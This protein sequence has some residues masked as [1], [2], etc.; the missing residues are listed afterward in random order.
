MSVSKKPG[1]TIVLYHYCG[2]SR[3]FWNRRYLLVKIFQ[4]TKNIVPCSVLR[5]IRTKAYLIIRINNPGLFWT[6]KLVQNN[7][8][9]T[10]R[11]KTEQSVVILWV[12]WYKNNYFL[13]ASSKLLQTLGE[14]FFSRRFLTIFDPPSPT[15]VQFLPSNV[16]FLGVISDPPIPP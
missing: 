9:Y 5:Q 3:F 15:E 6:I 4:L 1:Q 2:L 11:T 14:K 10:T 16:R 12:N 13:E 8:M 7:F